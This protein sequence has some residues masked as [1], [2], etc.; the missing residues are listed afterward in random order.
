MELAPLERAAMGVP[1]VRL[2]QPALFMRFDICDLGNLS[3]VSTVVVADKCK[4]TRHQ[5]QLHLV[6]VAQSIEALEYR[7]CF[8]DFGR[9]SPL[10]ELELPRSGRVVHGDPWRVGGV[11]ACSK[12]HDLFGRDE[13][14][15]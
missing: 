9:G 5:Y 1:V 13:Y 12:R 10:E 6:A 15:L 3:A 8:A 4:I 11:L 2:D 14:G 7:L